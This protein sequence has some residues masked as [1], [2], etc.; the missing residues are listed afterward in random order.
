MITYILTENC[1]SGKTN[2]SNQMFN[3][4]IS[5][6]AIPEVQNVILQTTKLASMKKEMLSYNA[7]KVFTF[8]FAGA[9]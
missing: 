4:Y 1:Y 9:M 5:L 7:W 3:Q 2:E 6:K 8:S